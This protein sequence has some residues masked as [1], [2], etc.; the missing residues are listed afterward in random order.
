MATMELFEVVGGAHQG[1]IVVRSECE[2]AGTFAKTKL[3]TGA[4]V[5]ALECRDGKLHYE[6]VEG[7]GPS[8]GWVTMKLLG[9]DQVVKQGSGSHGAS[10]EGMDPKGFPEVS[11]KEME[12]L[13]Q[14]EEKFGEARDGTQPA[15]FSRKS[16]PWHAP[17]AVKETSHELLKAAKAFK[18]TIVKPGDSRR[19]PRFWDVDSDGEEVQ[20]CSRC[21][22][23][24]GEHVY[25]NSNLRALQVHSE[26]MAHVVIEEMQDNEAKLQSGQC[27]K[28]QKNRLEYEIGWRMD[29]VP[30]NLRLAEKMGCLSSPQGLCCIVYNEL[31]RSVSVAATLEPAASVNLEYL[32][33]ALKVRRQAQREPLFSLDPVDPS[34]MERSLQ[35]K[36]Y[37]P[38]WLAGTSVGDVMFQADYFLKELALGEYTQPIV[39]MK[40]VFDWSELLDNHDKAWA[41][42][43]WFVVNKAEVR[44]A[45]DKT[46][47][48]CI[49]MGVE[50][51]E[52]SLHSDG[53][54]HDL[55]VTA[56]NHPLKKFAESFTKNFDLIA[57]R[58]SVV[59]HLRELAKASVIAKFLV[60]SGANIDQSWYNLADDIIASTSAEKFPEIPQ[61]W[62]M[63][64]LSRIQLKDGKLLDT[65]TGLQPNL[66]AI[67]GG[68][69]FGLDRF[70]L[71][72][73]SSL[74]PGGTPAGAGMQQPGLQGM[75]LG[76]SGRPMFMPQRF[77]L[78]QRGETPQGVDLN[79]DKF[80]LTEPERFAGML[81]ACSAGKGSLEASVTLGQAFLKSFRESSYQVL[82]AEHKSLL[83]SIFN[84]SLADRLQESD[85]FVPPD[86]NA[87]Y[88]LKLKNL[89][90]EERGKLLRRKSL[91]FD[92]S[93]AVGHAG[94][95]FPSSWT[96]QFQV[97][98]PS[99]SMASQEALKTSL[100]QL[101]VDDTFQQNL[102][103]DI[104]PEVAP[105]FK[106]TTED[107][108]LFM[109]YR[110]G[111]LEVRTFQEPDLAETIGV[112]FLSKAPRWSLH[113]A[114]G[115][116]AGH[117][118]EKIVKAKLYLEGGKYLDQNPS[119][120]RLSQ[121]HHYVV[122]QTDHGNVMVMEMLADGS[123]I[124]DVNPQAVEVRNSLSKLLQT[125]D[126]CDQMNVTYGDLKVVAS[127]NTMPHCKGDVRPSIRKRYAKALM[128][129][130]RNASKNI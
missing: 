75:Q 98:Q 21:Q 41:G 43:E 113:P 85:S 30:N 118:G 20:L 64:G 12:A 104:L 62:N 26:C 57:E 109:I 28:K 129:E 121:C 115:V 44:L 108:T 56:P 22:L 2:L 110:L 74:Y 73:R 68:V 46:I 55:P 86:P 35:A 45:E 112:V 18:E 23:P 16:F 103:E 25:N 88:V 15:S 51:R 14:Y 123:I 78:T 128:S 93:F 125:A 99:H 1:G 67:Y 96:A 95:E 107:G 119:G 91:F 47:I 24:L 60:D 82:K 13:R 100:V 39:G 102:M 122:L 3:S 5:K 84:R 49:K 52:Q 38:E 69:Q 130:I 101:Q 105:E 53:T 114:K 76:P 6:L 32:V 7:T 92:R 126:D 120:K 61:L 59:F 97:A 90:D 80:Q 4:V 89:I 106:K 72:Q 77:Q 8:I 83:Q 58:K 50:A 48:P 116:S 10:L 124:T 79:L 42:R 40:S 37:E 54:M 117:H 31:D 111:S 29:S 33:L 19:K 94:P 36:R 11:A 9:K 70:E 71:A 81:P 66:H 34:N 65:E 17:P 27:E 63:R 87:A 127:S